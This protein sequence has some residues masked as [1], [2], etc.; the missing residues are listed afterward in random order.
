[1]LLLLWAATNIGDRHV[2]ARVTR[3]APDVFDAP[4]RASL[5]LRRGRKAGPL[6]RAAIEALVAAD[7]RDAI[8]EFRLPVRDDVNDKLLGRRAHPWV[9]VEP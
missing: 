2:P 8:G 6:S 4:V 7:V 3:S 9:R 5:R 1:M